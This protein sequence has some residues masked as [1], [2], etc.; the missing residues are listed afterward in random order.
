[1]PDKQKGTK[2]EL[3]ESFKEE[4][5]EKTITVGGSESFKM[6]LLSAAYTL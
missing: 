3:P 2:I 1:M 6:R 5:R 4:F